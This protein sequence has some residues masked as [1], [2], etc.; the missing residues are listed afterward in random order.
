MIFD[1]LPASHQFE[2]ISIY[3]KEYFCE[4]T[5][6]WLCSYIIILRKIK[7]SENVEIKWTIYIS[8]SIS[9]DR[10]FNPAIKCFYVSCS[11]SPLYDFYTSSP[12]SFWYSL[13]RFLNSL[14]L[15]IFSLD[16]CLSFWFQSL[17]II[18]WYAHQQRESHVVFDQRWQCEYLVNIWRITFWLSLM[19]NHQGTSF[20]GIIIWQS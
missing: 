1:V 9:I 12:F 15:P 7:I 11:L 2:D 5:L 4:W 19:S 13:P 6:V 10:F 18:S 3:F 20:T 14:F 17:N 16:C 8:I